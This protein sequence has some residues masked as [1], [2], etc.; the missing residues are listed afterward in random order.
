MYE[1][2]YELTNDLRL[3]IL[4]NSSRSQTL[5]K[6]LPKKK[7]WYLQKKKNWYQ[8]IPSR[9]IPPD[10]PTPAKYPARDCRAPDKFRESEANQ[11][12]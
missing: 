12:A 2:P 1:L 7:N 6:A 4:E 8:L 10:S 3:R 11:P 5:A 9:Q